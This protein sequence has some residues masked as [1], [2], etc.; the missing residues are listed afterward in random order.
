MTLRTAGILLISS[1]ALAIVVESET[2]QQSVP[3]KPLS[4]TVH[5][6]SLLPVSPTHYTM[7]KTLCWVSHKPCL[8]T[9]FLHP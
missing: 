7:P 9:S 1:F 6:S 4:T 3:S 5:P 8:K 2:T